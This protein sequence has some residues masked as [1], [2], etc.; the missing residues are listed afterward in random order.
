MST[1]PLPVTNKIT[2][3][4]QKT[5]KFSELSAKF[6][7]G[8]SQHAPNGINYKIDSWSIEWG[9]LTSTE[10]TTVETALDANGSWGIFSWTPCYETVSK[11]FRVTVDGYTRRTEGGNGNFTITCNLEQTYD[12]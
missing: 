5:V 7:D 1:T 9:A 4:S 2:I 10:L 12:T 8:Y 6:G 11:N 3:N